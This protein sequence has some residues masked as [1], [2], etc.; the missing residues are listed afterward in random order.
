MLINLV[1]IQTDKALPLRPLFR[2]F[3]SHHM[4][5]LSTWSC[6][7]MWLFTFPPS[8]GYNPCFCSSAKGVFCFFVNEKSLNHNKKP[9]DIYTVG[10]LTSPFCWWKTKRERQHVDVWTR[11]AG[12]WHYR[13]RSR[14][15]DHADCVGPHLAEGASP[16]GGGLT[17]SG[18]PLCAYAAQLL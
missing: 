10:K 8:M 3:P 14:Q 16:R 12:F 7:R 15:A 1:Y 17:R 6:T 5:F 13:G 9:P 2:C 4:I 11:C 18:A